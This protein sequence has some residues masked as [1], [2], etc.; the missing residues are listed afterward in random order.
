MFCTRSCPYLN[1]VMGSRMFRTDYLSDM[2]VITWIQ[3]LKNNTSSKFQQEQTYG[4]E[5][6]SINGI[7]R[8]Q[9]QN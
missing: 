9:A 2:Y 4:L 6:G 5:Q 3:K 7:G 8:K 1:P